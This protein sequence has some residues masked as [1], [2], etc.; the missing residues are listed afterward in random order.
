[1]GKD[2]PRS[3]RDRNRNIVNRSLIKSL[4]SGVFDPTLFSERKELALSPFSF[5][6][7]SSQLAEDRTLLAYFSLSDYGKPHL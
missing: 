3:D 5:S 1:M 7:A 2:L 4:S 6:P